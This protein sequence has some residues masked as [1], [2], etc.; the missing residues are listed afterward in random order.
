M[1]II[2]AA[3]C[4]GNMQVEAATGSS[5]SGT[6]SSTNSGATNMIVDFAKT[7]FDSNL[8]AGD[9]GIIN[10]VIVNTGGQAADSVVVWLKGNNIIRT[11]KKLYVGKMNPAESTTIPVIFTIDQHAKTGLTAIQVEIDYYG[12]KYDGSADPNIASTTWELPITVQSNPLFEITPAKTTYYRDSLDNVDITGIS[13][14]N[15]NGVE[16][17]MSSG[18][19]T[20]I[21]SSRQYLG[22]ITVN[23]PFNL[24]YK[25][26]PSISGACLVSLNLAYTDDSGNKAQDNLTIGLNVEDNGVNFKVM[27]VS[28][29][30]TG[31]GEETQL[32]IVL[33]NVGDTQ[34]ED[35]TFRLNFS[36]PFSPVDTP[37]KYVERIT[38]GETTEAVFNVAVSWN[39][40]TTVYTIPLSIS[41][42]VGGT[43]YTVTKDI[44]LDVSGKVILEIMKVSSSSGTVSI[45]VAN[46]GTRTADG[47][48]A[49]LMV[50]T[51]STS[52][53]A[54]T[55]AQTGS[56]GRTRSGGN[57]SGA[58]LQRNFTGSGNFTGAD[59]QMLISYK[60]DI[61]STKQTTFTFSTTATGPATLLIEY[62][63]P[64]NQ[65]VTQ[66]ERITLSGGSSSLRGTTAST[67]TSWT[68]YALAAAVL[69]I[70]YLAWRRYKSKKKT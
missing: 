44:G 13:K 11:D 36:S 40:D 68:T 59:T 39:A 3:L 51:S 57:V 2:F 56:S 52:Q 26:K 61:K 67:G 55:T 49:T 65:R 50:P 6:S 33:K 28:Y 25:I 24:T 63:G 23:H 41:Y 48:K 37:E 46:I 27:N 22:D 34:A 54:A 64:N 32:G 5:S 17:T 7:S 43:S 21:G 58:G 30:P 4:L 60:S 16:T 19:A 8:K 69:V 1:L 29:D 18:C 47:V 62:T 45:D 10:L 66:T 70:A 12:Y 15:V 53:Q 31:P 42:R 9:S 14:D 38:A 20:I 35:V